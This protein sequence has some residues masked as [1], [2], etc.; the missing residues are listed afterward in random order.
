[1]FG[2][3]ITLAI[4]ALV[5]AIL[6]FGGIAGALADMAK[7][8]RLM[9]SVQSCSKQNRPY[10]APRRLGTSSSHASRLAFWKGGDPHGVN[11]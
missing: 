3:A 4:I 2:W 6:G 5:A 9:P 10:I 11:H 7:I 1:M 8:A